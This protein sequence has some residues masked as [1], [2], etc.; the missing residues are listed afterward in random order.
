MGRRTDLSFACPWRLAP[1]GLFSY[2][3]L[4][5][6]PSHRGGAPVPSLLGER[7]RVRR[8]SRGRR[9]TGE[10]SHLSIT[11]HV[12]LFSRFRA[13]LPDEA[14]GR[15]SFD[16]PPGATV[17]CL[18]D[19]LDL[20]AGEHGRVQLVAVNGQSHTDRDRDDEHVLHDGD[21]V[22]IFP[23]VVGG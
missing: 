8:D 10:R 16:L 2:N 13:L 21:Q 19:E 15:T 7:V 5:R 4:V 17:A 9:Q 18:L 14:R 6:S 22:R 1:P 3:G 12:Q 23:F 20:S 11:V